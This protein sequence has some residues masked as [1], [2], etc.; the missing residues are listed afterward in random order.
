MSGTPRVP[1]CRH[2]PGSRNTCV[3]TRCG[4]VLPGP[5]LRL[6][7]PPPLQVAA[8]RAQPSKE[9][10]EWME[11][12]MALRKELDATQEIAQVG[13]SLR[14]RG[15]GRRNNC[16]PGAGQGSSTA[17]RPGCRYCH[18]VGCNLQLHRPR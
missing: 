7:L 16:F 5:S 17:V 3:T 1:L 9:E 13:D 8:E 2:G 6:P 4:V 11:R 12:S 15:R 14:A 18:V 10:G